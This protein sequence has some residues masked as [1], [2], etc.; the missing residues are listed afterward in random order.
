MKIVVAGYGSRGDIEPCAVVGRELMRRGHD[1]RIALPPNMFDMAEGAGLTVVA[2]GRD[3][4]EE[5]NPAMGLVRDL[6]PNIR[7]PFALLPDLVE[8]VSQVKAEK[9]ATLTTLAD[10]A[11]LLVAGFNEQSLAANIAEYHGIPLV[12]LHCFPPEMSPSGL[13]HSAVSKEADDAQRR[14]LGLPEVARPATPL[15]IQGYEQLLLPGLAYGW[16]ESAR[17]RP[18]VG[19]LTLEWPMDG[20]DDVLS[21]VAADSP[22]IYFGLGSTPITSFAETV[23]MVSAACARVGERV[24]ICSGPN[25]FTDIPH[26]GRVKI[27]GPVNHAAVFPA[28]RA[29]VHHGG[30]GTTAAGLRAGIPTLIL[31]QWLDQPAWAAAITQLEAGAGRPFAATTEESLVADLRTILAP[32][33]AAR[34]R[35]VA[36]QMT[37]PAESASRA[38]DIL[39]DVVRPGRRD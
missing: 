39:E 36:G 4:V 38:A 9:S 18:F 11:D 10:G 2:Y 15:E 20:D 8:R 1:V 23:A 32:Q 14:A 24:L 22:P 6:S 27:V 26:S 25:D 3:S 19:T 17:R 12:G 13:L 35:E 30:S 21:W 34:A 37:K 7:N 28:C 5:L 33:C 31:W 29:L 16:G